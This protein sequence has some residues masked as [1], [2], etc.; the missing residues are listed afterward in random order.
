MKLKV[1]ESF[2]LKFEKSDW[3]RNPEFGLLDIILE[4]HPE[5][6]LL[7]SDDILQ[8]SKNSIYG[9]QDMPSV[10]QIT[11]AAIYKELK[12]LNYRDL[13]YHFIDSRICEQFVK[14]DIMRP[15]SFQVMQKYISKI[16]EKSLENLLHSLNR[17]A[18]SSGLED[19]NKIRQ[20]STVVES[21]IHYPTNNS[22]VWDCIKESHR[23]LEHLEKENQGLEYRDYLKG[24]KK[25]FFKIN[26]T[27]SGDK[28]VD[29]F[30]KQLVVFTKSINQISNIVK[31]KALL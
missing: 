11:R 22:L 16:S 26:N 31:K 9:R 3:S 20:D 21:N 12:G 4:T 6:I 17:I 10:E 25:T 24:A 15:Y 19:L 2:V 28:R 5:L 14:I 30:N 27:K 7:V 29:L 8:D 13:E 1:F 23:L 18:I